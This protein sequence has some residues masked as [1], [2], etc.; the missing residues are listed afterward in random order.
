MV[1]IILI[2][3]LVGMPILL[4]FYNRNSQAYISYLRN[5]KGELPI[6][7][8]NMTRKK[9]IIGFIKTF[10]FGYLKHMLLHIIVFVLPFLVLPFITSVS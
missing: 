6:P 2:I 5:G 10:L 1:D 4:S 3:I 8:T 7:L 9:F